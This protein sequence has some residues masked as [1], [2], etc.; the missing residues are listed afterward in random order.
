VSKVEIRQHLSLVM[1]KKGMNP[2]ELFEF[3]TSI[4]SQFLSLSRRLPKDEIIA[5][6]L[7]VASEAY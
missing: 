2:S 4:Q 3:L 6:V 7:D 1:M 5:V